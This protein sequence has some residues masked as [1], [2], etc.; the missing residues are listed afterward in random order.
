MAR[1]RRIRVYESRLPG[2]RAEY[3]GL[4][5]RL[6]RQSKQ[7]R[8]QGHIQQAQEL[9]DAAIQAWRLHH[10]LAVELDHDPPAAA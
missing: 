4:S 2:D 7:A 3:L 8:R 10:G 5:R 9:E 1:R 6:V